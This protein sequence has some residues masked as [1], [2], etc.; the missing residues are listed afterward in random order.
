MRCILVILDGLGDRSHPIL[1][2]QTPLQAAHTPHLDY[3]AQIGMN[4][5]YHSYLQG[6]PLSSEIAHFLIFGYDLEEFPGRGYLEASGNGVEIDEKEVV[7]LCHFCSVREEADKSLILIKECLDITESEM[8]TLKE[9]VNPYTTDEISITFIPAQKSDGFLVLSGTVSPAI[10]DSNPIYEGRPLISVQPIDDSLEAQ[11]TAKE[12]NRYLCWVY[13][14]LCVHPLN[15]NRQKK[16]LLPINFLAT[17]RAGKKR[18]LLPFYEKCGLLGLS[19]SSGPI[20]WGLCKELG[21]DVIKV[22]DSGDPERDLRERLQLA[23]DARKHDFVHV[24]TKMADQAAHTKDPHYKKEIIESLDRAMAFAVQEILPD[25]ET[26]LVVTADH[27]TASVGTMIHTGETVPLTM[28]GKYPRRDKVTAFNE[29]DCAHGGLGIVK[30]NELIYLI[31]N[32][33]DRA[34]MKGLMDTSADQPYYP[35]HYRILTIDGE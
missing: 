30:G 7:L 17:Q 33:L 23:Y 26:L 16:N 2:N 1:N 8:S 29:I 35:G 22:R 13:Q 5:L 15:R 19:I 11:K 24:H 10:T 3:L 14:R 25:S 34:K 18:F 20:Y 21:I 12:L 27:A 28:V 32:F 31:L 4:G 6:I 9:A